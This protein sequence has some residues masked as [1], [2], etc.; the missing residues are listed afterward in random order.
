MKAALAK[1]Q[2]RRAPQPAL[3]RVRADIHR[4]VGA[5]VDHRSDAEIAA[6]VDAYVDDRLV[7]WL[8]AAWRW[9][10]AVLGELDHLQVPVAQALVR[11][12]R[13]D[14]DQA[15]QQREI[16]GAVKSSI[17]QIVDEDRPIYRPFARRR[18]AED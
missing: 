12:E 16:D 2:R 10:R 17:D 3:V 18:P 8:S 14:H 11:I 5:M 9:H 15:S 6:Q 7:E 4:L 1:V 13:L